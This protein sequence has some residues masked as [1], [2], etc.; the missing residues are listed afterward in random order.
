MLDVFSAMF[1][2]L[3]FWLLLVHRDARAA[4]ERG[5]RWLVLL[6]L[7]LGGALAVKWTG[8]AVIAAAGLFVVVGEVVWA[9]RD[10]RPRVRSTLRM[11]PL[12]VACLLLIPAGLYVASYAGWFTNVEHTEPGRRLCPEEGCPSGVVETV[13]AWRG[14]QADIFRFHRDLVPDHPYRSSAWEWP[15]LRRPVLYYF[16]QCKPDDPPEDGCVVE[17]GNRAKVLGLGNP[18]LWW[19]ALAS[20]PVLVWLAV[21]RRDWRAAALILFLVAQY[22]PLALTGKTGYFFYMTPLVAFMGLSVALVAERLA[23][24]PWLRVVPAA[25]AV[26]AVAMFVYFY[27]VYAAVE[28]DRPTLDQRLWLD[29]WR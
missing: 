23:R 2:A 27:P 25:L 5:D 6:G 17:P 18:A 14:E 11:A 26:V 28:A 21:R 22:L 3:A 7:A 16:E 9:R 19:S 4:G 12:L 20:Y 13:D 8:I 29:S 10:G 15:V 24:I 1:V